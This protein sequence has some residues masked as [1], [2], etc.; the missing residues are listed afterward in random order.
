M[1]LISGGEVPL[2][3]VEIGPNINKKLEAMVIVTRG[4]VFSATRTCF[5]ALFK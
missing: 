3:N 1:K 4:N 2:M 5:Q